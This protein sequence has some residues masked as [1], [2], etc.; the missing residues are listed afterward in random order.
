[1]ALRGLRDDAV[2]GLEDRLAGA[3]VLLQRRHRDVRELRGEVEDVA[4]LG[5]AEAVDGL[6]VIAYHG[7]A[8]PV[9]AKPSHDPGLDHVGVLV[10]V[11]EHLVETAADFLSRGLVGQ[12]A[13][14]EQEQVVVVEH[15]ALALAVH[16]RAEQRLEV[17]LVLAAVRERGLEHVGQRLARV[18]ASRVDV[19]AGAFLREPPVRAAQVQLGADHAH[20]ILGVTAVQDRERRVQSDRRSVQS[21]QTRGDGVV[22]AAPNGSAAERA[23]RFLA[24]AAQDAVDPPRHLGRRTACEGEQEDAPGVGARGDVVCHP[25]GE[26]GGLASARAGD[27]EQRA[28][29]VGDG[30]ALRGVELRQDCTQRL[31][32]DGLR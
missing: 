22:R 18:H 21:E 32:R 9:R 10:L 27:D 14:P 11:H 15:V 25:V 6:R 26:R 2:G 4:D 16:V 24:D 28:V 31:G 30:L 23:R 7:H 19:Q 3:V 5:R 20:Q 1:M 8:G 17:V 12:Q 13:V 29:A